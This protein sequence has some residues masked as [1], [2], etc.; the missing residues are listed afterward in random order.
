MFELA[1]FQL[2]LVTRPSTAL[3]F[4]DASVALLARYQVK[5]HVAANVPIRSQWRDP[6]ALRHHSHVQGSRFCRDKHKRQSR[7]CLISA[8]V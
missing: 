3:D 1:Q 6:I 5:R 7:P 2:C 8:K 4:E